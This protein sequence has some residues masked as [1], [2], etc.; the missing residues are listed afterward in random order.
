VEAAKRAGLEPIIDALP[1]G[2][3]TLLS[4]TFAAQSGASPTTLSGGQWQR[5]ALARAAM[6][7]EAEI[8]IL[9]EPTAGLDLEGETEVVRTLSE[10]SHDVTKIIVSH[11]REA[12]R[13]A[14]RLIFVKDGRVIERPSYTAD[15]QPALISGRRG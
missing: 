9:D 5:L 12:L 3:D 2:Y 13:D 7:D 10:W 6:R 11:R 4:L 1:A 8:L 15:S 14:D